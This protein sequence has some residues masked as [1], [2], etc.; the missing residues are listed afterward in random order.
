MLPVLRKH[1]PMIQ[2]KF[3]DKRIYQSGLKLKKD[4]IIRM[5]HLAQG[6][7]DIE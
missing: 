2:Q 6:M 5:K 7:N 1:F 4:E 3:D